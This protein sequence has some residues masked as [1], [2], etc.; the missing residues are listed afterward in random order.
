MEFSFTNV[1]I[2]DTI[3][4]TVIRVSDNEILLDLDYVFEGTVY[5]NEYTNDKVNS[6][7]DIV[8]EGDIVRVVVKKIDEDRGQVLCSRL[9]IIKEEN[10]V[11]IVELFNNGAVIEAKVTEAVNKGLLL[12]YLGFEMFMHESQVSLDDTPMDEFVG[13]TVEVK[14]SD[15]DERKQ[16]IKVSRKSLLIDAE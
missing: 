10:F 4:A 16:K 14:I 13:K 3:D 11:K 1:R 5:L 9:G 7:K 6:F 12:S 2:G 15:L 8:T